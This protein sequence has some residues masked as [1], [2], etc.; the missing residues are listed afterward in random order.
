MMELRHLRYFVA[1]AEEL[2]FG[3][4][5]AR[6]GISQPPLSQQLQALELELGARLLERTNRHVHLTAAGRLFLDEARLTLAQAER[7]AGVA[8]RA[9]RGEIG[10]LSLGFF[11]SAPL[12]SVVTRTI[13]AFRQSFPSIRVALQEMPTPMQLDALVE[14][15]LDIGFIR[16]PGEPDVAA[17]LRAVEL[18][19]EPLA[20]VTRADD[21]R[22]SD[23][24]GADLA[25]FAEDP[26]VF[27]PRTIGTSLY[28][29]VFQL[30]RQAGFRPRISQEARENAIIV[31]LVAAGLGVS[32][33]PA[34]FSAI[35]VEN[36]VYRPLAVP[37]TT[38]VWLVYRD[39]ASSP[40]GRRFVDFAMGRR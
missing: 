36:V 23:G 1:L 21:P 40:V 26:F 13:F 17:P 34:C 33:L 8:G 6:L 11:A 22:V 32:V 19:R 39:D 37:A 3:R 28:E 18:H 10:E 14:R 16:S 25:E 7:A 15:R 27:F 2:H 29:Q 12:I 24:R 31:G 30:C 4:A 20:L 9:Q 5:A 35:Q 38:A